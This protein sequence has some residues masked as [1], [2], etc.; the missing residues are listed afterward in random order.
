MCF[1]IPEIRGSE[2]DST[3]KSSLFIMLELRSTGSNKALF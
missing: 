3:H 2:R 1:Q